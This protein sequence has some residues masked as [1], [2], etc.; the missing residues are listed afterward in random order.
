MNVKL[1]TMVDGLFVGTPQSLWE[2]RAPSAI[3]K[4]AA[5]GRREIGPV[6]FVDDAQADMEVH[7][8]V[9]KAIHHYA[10]DHYASWI[11]EEQLPP[12]TVPAAFGE[13]IASL[14][15]TEETLCIGDILQ[16]GSAVVQISQGRQP[17]WKINMHRDNPRMAFLFQKTGRTGWYYRVL[18]TGFV[19]AGD[20]ITL[21]ERP[22]P[23]W[24]VKMV[25]QARLTKRVSK[26]DAE[27]LAEL[28]VLAEGWREAFAKMAKGNRKEDTRARLE[29]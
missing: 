9:D 10:T 15:M 20:R 18:E 25:T 1:E 22:E 28:A 7:G 14:G 6:G 19:E 13:N 11:E 5:D 21:L 26:E 8:G 24:T 29:G 2:G 4:I 3:A 16:L 17:C 27:R 12:E 23:S